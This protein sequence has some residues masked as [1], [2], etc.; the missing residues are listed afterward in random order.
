MGVIA[1]Q[2]VV[3]NIK[4]N[5]AKLDNKIDDID[6]SN[7]I[8]NSSKEQAV[9][10][11]NDIENS[12][13]K[14]K[15][16]NIRRFWVKNIKIFG[17]L[18][19]GVFPYIVAVALPFT[20]QTLLGDIPFYRQEEFKFAHYEETV[21]ASGIIDNKVIYNLDEKETLDTATFISKWE[22]KSDGK[23]YRSIKE[24]ESTYN[25]S[26]D[27]LM[28]MA[29]NNNLN[30]EKVFGKQKKISFEVREEEP[31]E[32][33]IDYIKFVRHSINHE[34]VMYL[35][36]DSLSNLGYTAATVF[37][38]ISFVFCILSWRVNQSNYDFNEH[39]K[40]IRNKYPNINIAAVKELFKEQK[41]RFERFAHQE[42]E[43][44]KVLSIEIYD[45]PA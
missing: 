31:K 16:E 22:Q 30:F 41:I 42:E 33:N 9:V 32:E 21:D 44:Q 6:N 14:V 25:Y 43:K 10:L 11:I 24:Y 35:P 13:R 12:I 40:N 5:I 2:Y 3:Q 28:T 23:W 7:I 8:N 4:E 38:A 27:D 45:P 15:G 34:D 1:D 19:Q 18:L 36:Q 39:C 17:R 20:G 29:N 26:V 37:F